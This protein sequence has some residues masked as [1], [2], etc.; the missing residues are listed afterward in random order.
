MLAKKKKKRNT[1][2]LMQITAW[3]NNYLMKVDGVNMKAG[4]IQKSF[5]IEPQIKMCR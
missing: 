2:G 3:K 1:S 5:D 4:I